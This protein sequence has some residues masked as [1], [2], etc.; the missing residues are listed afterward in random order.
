MMQ[1]KRSKSGVQLAAPANRQIIG[2]I[3]PQGPTT[4]SRPWPAQPNCLSMLQTEENKL[5]RSQLL[6]QSPKTTGD[7]NFQCRCNTPAKQQEMA[8][9]VT[10]DNKE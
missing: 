4:T 5:L 7:A 6:A 9:K 8:L 2:T 10:Q 3:S 1:A